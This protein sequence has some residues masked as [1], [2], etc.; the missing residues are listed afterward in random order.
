MAPIMAVSRNSSNDENKRCQS[1]RY[2]HGS[3]DIKC[4]D[5]RN[6]SQQVAEE[7]EEECGQQEGQIAVCL[8]FP[9]AWNCHFIA[10]DEDQGLQSI[11][12]SFWSLSFSLLVREVS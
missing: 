9:N 6:Q 1:Q 5:K 4:P 7:N 3:R 11:L 8:L 10:D 12:K 2:P